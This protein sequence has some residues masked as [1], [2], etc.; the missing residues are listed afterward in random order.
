VGSFHINDLPFSG[1]R[2]T[3]A[4]SYHGCEELRA[5]A[6]GVAARPA[7]DLAAQAF[8]RCNGLLASCLGSSRPV[9]TVLEVVETPIADPAALIFGAVAFVQTPGRV[10]ERELRVAEEAVVVIPLGIPRI[11]PVLSANEHDTGDEILLPRQPPVV[12]CRRHAR[13]SP[14]LSKDLA[15]G[16][17]HPPERSEEG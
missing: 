12:I 15:F 14:Y 11:L 17:E 2:R 13:T 6:R 8:I 7:L 4:R 16:G 1:E 10:V 3:N 5:P 9:E